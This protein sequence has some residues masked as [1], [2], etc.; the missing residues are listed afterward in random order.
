MNK[1][2]LLQYLDSD[3][4][5]FGLD[6][7]ASHGFLTATVV[8]KPFDGWLKAF[9]EGHDGQVP[10]QVKQALVRWQDEIAQTLKAEEPVELPFDGSDEALSFDEDSD[11]VAWSIGFVDAMYADDAPDWFDDAETVDDVAML[12]LPMIALSGIDDE[13]VQVR[14]EDMMAQY[15]N[16]LED[17]L[18]ELFLL[19][20]TND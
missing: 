13:M 15:A 16:A 6:P 2:Q 5:Q 1:E 11:I 3:D 19:F 18:T 8:G 14:D 7:V 10:D 20:H 4:N 17:N 9:F 12:T